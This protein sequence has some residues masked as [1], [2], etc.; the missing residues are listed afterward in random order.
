[1]QKYF[2]NYNIRRVVV[3]LGILGSLFM[4]G[5]LL[6]QEV[7]TCYMYHGDLPWI[8]DTKPKC[9]KIRVIKISNNWCKILKGKSV[10]DKDWGLGPDKGPD[11]PPYPNSKYQGCSLWNI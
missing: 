4:I 10:Y 11:A 7:Q 8:E 3:V 2:E 9:H 6:S 1:M 5:I